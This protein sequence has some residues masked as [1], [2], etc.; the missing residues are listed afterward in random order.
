[1]KRKLMTPKN[2]YSLT[3]QV[4]HI[5]IVLSATLS[6]AVW[7]AMDGFLLTH[8]IL[9]FEKGDGSAMPATIPPCLV[10]CCWLTIRFFRLPRIFKKKERERK[11]R[12]EREKGRKEEEIMFKEV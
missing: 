2:L 11:E 6:Y 3:E 1:M 5:P 7:S 9:S 12:K 4:I 8:I 10:P